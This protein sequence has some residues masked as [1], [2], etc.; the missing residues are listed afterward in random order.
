MHPLSIRELPNA[1]GSDHWYAHGVVAKPYLTDSLLREVCEFAG[2]SQAPTLLR[3]AG[4]ILGVHTSNPNHQAEIVHLCRALA[5]EGV[6]VQ[7]MAEE[8]VHELSER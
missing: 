8:I 3:R 6:L 5:G 4:Q 2:P 7:E 1:I